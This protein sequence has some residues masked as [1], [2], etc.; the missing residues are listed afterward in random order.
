V[1]HWQKKKGITKRWAK[2]EK[3][4]TGDLH[5]N[6]N[7]KRNG[8]RQKRFKAF[9]NVYARERRG[10]EGVEKKSL[11][12]FQTFGGGRKAEEK[13]GGGGVKKTPRRNQND[14]K[15]KGDTNV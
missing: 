2:K 11:M 5:K 1:H 12:T 9:S 6:R 14:S 15:H 8:G 3:S 4:A 7:L 10:D 13:T